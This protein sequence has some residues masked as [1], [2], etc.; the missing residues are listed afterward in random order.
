VQSV[1]RAVSGF[2]LGQIDGILGGI[3]TLMGGLGKLPKG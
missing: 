3:Q 2:V 1:S